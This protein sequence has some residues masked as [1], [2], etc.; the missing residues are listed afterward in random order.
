MKKLSTILL[1]LLLVACGNHTQTTSGKSYLAKYKDKS[2]AGDG[3]I[4][5]KLRAVASVEPTL[6][7]PA[8]IGLARIDGGRLSNIPGQEIAAW[9][10]QKEKLGD[11]FGEFV[12]LNPMVAEMVSQ[13]VGADGDVMNKIRLGAARQHLDAVLIYE[14]YSKTDNDSTLLSITDL[15]IIGG[16]I[17]PSR[18]IEAEGFA[19]AMLID[20]M[21]GYPYGTV[22]VTVDKE[23]KYTQAWGS[24]DEVVDMSDAIKIKAAVKLSGEAREMLLKL[25]AELAEKRR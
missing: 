23:E 6:T 22:D 19:N 10:E 3:G 25:R 11:G 12:P 5:D 24:H 13:S 4:E 14:V 20:V 18:A 15:T 1:C 9:M 16:Y 17:L 2:V 21:Q 8:R 7:F